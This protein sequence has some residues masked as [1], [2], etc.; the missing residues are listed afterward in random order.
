MTEKSTCTSFVPSNYRT[1]KMRIGKR[2]PHTSVAH[3]KPCLTTLFN[4]PVERITPHIWPRSKLSS[5][6]NT[7]TLPL[8]HLRLPT[9]T[10]HLKRPLPDADAVVAKIIEGSIPVAVDVAV[11]VI[12]VDV[13]MGAIQDE[14]S[15]EMPTLGAHTARFRDMPPPIAILN[16]RIRPL[17]QVSTNGVLLN[18]LHPHRILHRSRRH[19]V[20]LLHPPLIVI[21]NSL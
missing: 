6:R 3:T 7:L 11:V 19:P 17:I 8:L 14:V 9:R 16:T 13:A 5:L 21:L 10:P 20:L 15:P 2:G 18:R 4:P 12:V 1:S